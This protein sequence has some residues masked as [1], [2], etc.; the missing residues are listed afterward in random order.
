MAS[1]VQKTMFWETFKNAKSA[2]LHFF[3]VA[4]KG[5]KIHISYVSYP[6]EIYSQFVQ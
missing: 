1:R 6:Q 2:I 5:A 4:V 3:P